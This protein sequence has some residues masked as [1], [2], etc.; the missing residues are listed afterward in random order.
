M[1]HRVLSLAALFGFWLA[2]AQ[3]QAPASSA[4][5]ASSSGKSSSSSSSSESPTY[6]I[7][8]GAYA[9]PIDMTIFNNIADL[10][11]VTGEAIEGG[12]V[13]VSLGTYLDRSTAQRI[14]S[15]AQSRGY[16]KC[17]IARDNSKFI[18]GMGRQQTH[19]L[20]FSA[21]KKLDA[22]TVTSKLTSD[23]AKDLHIRYSSGYYRL[24]LGTYALDNSTLIASYRQALQNAGIMEMYSRQ[25]RT[26]TAGYVPPRIDQPLPPIV[27]ETP[28]PLATEVKDDKMSG[29][30]TTEVKND[31]MSGK[32]TTDKKDSKMGK[33]KTS[34][35]TTP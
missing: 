20:Q 17:Y 28:K 34:T 15:I 19:T 14:A 32:G 7:R 33:G 29:T 31:K 11:A 12:L 22:R 35:T 2:G 10:G 25:F 16:A 13:R 21:V 3:A 8:L 9:K 6:K 26:P 5:T 1:K 30:N 18:D 27:N 4:S 23:I 24:S